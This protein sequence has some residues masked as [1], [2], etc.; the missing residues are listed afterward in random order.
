MQDSQ[1][2]QYRNMLHN[3]GPALNSSGVMASTKQVNMCGK[4]SQAWMVAIG[5]T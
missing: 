2:D 5:A 4:I 1:T 3:G